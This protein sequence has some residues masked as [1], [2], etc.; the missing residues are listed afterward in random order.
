MFRLTIGFGRKRITT[1]FYNK[2]YNATTHSSANNAYFKRT[3]FNSAF[4][5]SSNSSGSS[6]SNFANNTISAFNYKVSVAYQP[7]D[8]SDPIY[9]KVLVAKNSPTGEDNYFINQRESNDLF[10]GVADGVG[11]WIEMGEDSSAISRE[12][13]SKLS[14]F[15]NKDKFSS[16]TKQLLIESFNEV[17]KEGVVKAGSTTCIAAHLKPNGELEVSNLG[18]SWCGVFRN[19]SLVY[20]TNFQVLS[21]NAPYQ[22]SIIPKYILD[23]AKTKGSG[24]I[25]NTPEEADDYKFQ[26]MKNDVVILATDGVTD[27]VDTGDLAN[28]LRDNEISTK[29]QSQENL[30]RITK[31]LVGKT[32]ALSKDPQFPSIFSQELSKITGANY[33]GGK[34][35]D[36]TLVLVKVE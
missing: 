16:T 29:T 3:F 26:L 10:C 35:D 5:A 33:V 13:C 30:D 28:F 25:R 21:F 2:L 7:K 17:V 34:E 14:E 27:N 8:R 31:D 32:V 36:I 6:S 11:G 4:N 18:D 20:H 23:S 1:S 19:D 12:L 9:E 24:F 22:L 15:T